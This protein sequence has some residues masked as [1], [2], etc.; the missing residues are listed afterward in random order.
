[1]SFFIEMCK[2]YPCNMDEECPYGRPG[3]R[4]KCHRYC[5]GNYTGSLDFLP[6]I[7]REKW[8]EPAQRPSQVGAKGHGI[9]GV[10]NSDQQGREWHWGHIKKKV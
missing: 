9:L 5:D 6:W 7:D 2:P 8:V 3:W 4:E 10:G 1:M